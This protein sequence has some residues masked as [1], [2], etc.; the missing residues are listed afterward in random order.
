[1]AAAAEGMGLYGPVGTFPLLGL[2]DPCS[3]LTEYC[4]VLVLS[5]QVLVVVLELLEPAQLRQ[6]VMLETSIFLIEGP[7]SLLSDGIH[8][9][10]PC[11]A[12]YLLDPLGRQVKCS[13]V[14]N[15]VLRIL[16]ARGTRCIMA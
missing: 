10:G 8:N 2:Q 11:L 14:G 6:L 5:L 9:V 3:D 4:Q 7:F 1:M 16:G 13:C 15:Q 12:D